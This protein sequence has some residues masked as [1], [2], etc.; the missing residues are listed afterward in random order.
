MP[1]VWRRTLCDQSPADRFS[2]GLRTV[3][4][5]ELRAHRPHVLIGAVLGNLH[6]L[7]DFPIVFFLRPPIAKLRA[8]AEKGEWACP[9]ATPA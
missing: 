7:T 2:Y 3:D 4:R 6:D 8:R 5:S 9:A 1:D